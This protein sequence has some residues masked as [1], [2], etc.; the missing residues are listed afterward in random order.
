MLCFFL[1]RNSIFGSFL[2]DKP[3][4][5]KFEDYGI[6]IKNGFEKPKA[7]E[8]EINIVWLTFVR[9]QIWL[10]VQNKDVSAFNSCYMCV[11]DAITI[12]V[13][14]CV[15]NVIYVYMSSV[16]GKINEPWDETEN[17]IEYMDWLRMK[18]PLQKILMRRLLPMNNVS[19][20]Y[21]FWTWYFG[22]DFVVFAKI[23]DLFASSSYWFAAS[24]HL[25]IY[26]SDLLQLTSF[27]FLAA[28]GSF[29]VSS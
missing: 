6:I 15:D 17:V 28:V 27:N 25:I 16:D 7:V 1:L 2:S 19:S 18:Q 21:A 23:I 13:F 24:L 5:H 4:W 9:V 26:V 11:D 12:N 8:T 3:P 22:A 10:F 20:T 14:V 29:R